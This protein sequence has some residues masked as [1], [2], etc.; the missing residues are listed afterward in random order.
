M[1]R[2][3]RLLIIKE[4]QIKTT[5]RCHTIASKITIKKGDAWE[6]SQW[7]KRPAI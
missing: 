2:Y 3:S 4:M 6:M 1:K 7:V 5:M